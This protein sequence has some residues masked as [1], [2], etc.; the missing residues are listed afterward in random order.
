MAA[1][2]LV[3]PYDIDPQGNVVFPAREIS[4]AVQ[5][6][7][8]K[9]PCEIVEGLQD[10]QKKTAEELGKLRDEL[11]VVADCAVIREN[12]ERFLD[13][14]R[15]NPAVC[16]ILIYEPALRTEMDALYD[17]LSALKRPVLPLPKRGYDAA[18]FE[19]WLPNVL[20]RVL[21]PRLLLE[22]AQCRHCAASGDEFVVQPTL[23]RAKGRSGAGS[24]H[25]NLTPN[26]VAAL[27]TLMSHQGNPLAWDRLGVGNVS[28]GAVQREVSRLRE[29]LTPD[30]G[31][32]ITERDYELEC[33]VAA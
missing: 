9:F 33:H 3:R 22:A 14:C 16:P 29:E 4:K 1:I 13:W 17:V 25:F 27:T 24:F 6:L 5:K 20:N 28:R 7:A 15:Q 8:Y 31:H 18:F 19:I 26:Q 2:L 32:T 21:P 11:V 30:V 10:L 23:K 12:T